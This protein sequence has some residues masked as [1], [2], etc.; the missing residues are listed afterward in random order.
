M[1]EE[2]AL[3]GT[4]PRYKR[5]IPRA[6]SS[7]EKYEMKYNDFTL[8][9]IEAVFNKLGGAEGVKCFLSGQSEVVLKVHLID[10]DADPFIPKGWSVAEHQRG[11]QIKL[12]PEKLQL[13]LSPNQQDGKRIEGYK[14]RWELVE[15]TILNVNALDY[16]LANPYL[17]REEWKG[18]KVFFWGTLYQDADGNHYVR[19]LYW[20]GRSWCWLYGNTESKLGSNSPAA[21]LVL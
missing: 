15:K 21:I 14:L 2:E 13:Y 19:F 3:G 5:E 18:Q 7:K 1:I 8:G 11:G 12:D 20:G 10:C 4:S 17:I 6:I 16:L 9:Q